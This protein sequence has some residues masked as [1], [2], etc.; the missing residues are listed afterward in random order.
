M[1]T[2]LWLLDMYSKFHSTKSNQLS[3]IMNQST[4]NRRG[5]FDSKSLQRA[6]SCVIINI[7]WWMKINQSIIF[8]TGYLSMKISFNQFPYFNEC[9]QHFSHSIFNLLN[10]F[11][12]DF[13]I[14]IFVPLHQILLCHS[15]FSFFS[16][17]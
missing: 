14:L 5:K 2:N 16:I 7:S 3:S 6:Q 8:A 17:F 4:R 10:L 9:L 1:R 12:K 15:T 13:I 11:K